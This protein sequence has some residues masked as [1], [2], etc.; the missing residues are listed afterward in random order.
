MKIYL[1]DFFMVQTFLPDIVIQC[2]NFLGTIYNIMWRSKKVH[3]IKQHQT[4]T[5]QLQSLQRI[6][7][8]ALAL[9]T[10]KGKNDEARAI[11]DAFLNFYRQ[12][13]KYPT[14][15]YS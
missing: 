11:M 2:I 9:N 8:I 3:N 5:S 6:T 15:N 4:R 14:E 12:C 13:Q 10:P 1:K 7:F